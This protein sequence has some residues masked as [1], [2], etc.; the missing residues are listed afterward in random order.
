MEVLQTISPRRPKQP[1]RLKEFLHKSPPPFPLNLPQLFVS[2]EKFPTGQVQDCV[3]LR[4]PDAV[5]GEED[6]D[7]AVDCDGEREQQE[8]AAVPQPNAVVDVGA[9]V[10][11]LA[12]DVE[13]EFSLTVLCQTYY[14]V[15][16]TV[17][18]IS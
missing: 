7:G 4:I 1:E 2:V 5:E 11:E 16:C 6:G 9:V 18:S 3:I 10:V 12:S 14:T 17:R 8:P 15:H 13:A